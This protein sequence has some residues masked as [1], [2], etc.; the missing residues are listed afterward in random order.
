MSSCLLS[1]QVENKPHDGATTHAF[2][3]EPGVVMNNSLL[4]AQ[5]HIGNFLW[6]SAL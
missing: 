3:L 4:G 1:L 2:I 5:E 6:H